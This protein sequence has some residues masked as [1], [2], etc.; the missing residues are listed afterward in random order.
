[1]PGTQLQLINASASPEVQIN[2]NFISVAPA[3]LYARKATTTLALTWGYY[4]GI[5]PGLFTTI[6]DGTVAL[7][8]NATNYIECDTAGTVY[9]NTSA[10]TVGRT[11][12]YS[13]VTV[14]GVITSYIDYRVASGT[15]TVMLISPDASL[16]NAVPQW[17]K[18]G[19]ALAYS[20]F[21]IAGLQKSNTLFSLVAAGIIHATAVRHS[22]LFTGA[23]ITTV[24][25]SIGI[26]GTNDKFSSA[27][28]IKQAVPTVPFVTNMMSVESHTGATTI[29]VTLDSTGANLDQLSQGVLDVWALLSKL[30]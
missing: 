18:V 23:G 26:S 9:K 8:D 24:T 28:D 2:E 22:T 17:V 12:L 10:F 15:N 27:Y 5:L 1:M 7:T 25:V 21:S 6:A 3:A 30:P 4:G 29:T 11:R 16:I 20:A 14:G 19:A 13:V